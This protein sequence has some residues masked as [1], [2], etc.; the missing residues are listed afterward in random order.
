MLCLC[1]AISNI[2]N[3]KKF[4]KFYIVSVEC[5]GMM[6]HDVYESIVYS[7]RK[8]LISYTPLIAT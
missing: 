2:K 4:I 5:E 3:L 6:S 8:L 7:S 1:S